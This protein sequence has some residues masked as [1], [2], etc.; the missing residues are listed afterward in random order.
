M[1]IPLDMN[2]GFRL[3]AKRPPA[4]PAAT[5]SLWVRDRKPSR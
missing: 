4:G 5:I 2:F 1:V 3:G